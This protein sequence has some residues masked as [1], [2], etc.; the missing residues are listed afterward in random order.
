METELRPILHDISLRRDSPPPHSLGTT[1]QQSAMEVFRQ[2]QNIDRLLKITLTKTNSSD[3]PADAL[4]RLAT[5]LPVER[6]LLAQYRDFVE[7]NTTSK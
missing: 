7:R 1:W 6:A 4:S 3:T 2:A 5:E